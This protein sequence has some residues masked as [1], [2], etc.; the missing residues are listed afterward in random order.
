MVRSGVLWVIRK[1]LHALIKVVLWVAELALGLA[2]FAVIVNVFG[3]YVFK[4]PLNGSVEIV[5]LLLVV[6]VYFSLAYTEVRQGHVTMEEVVD[7]FPRRMK[8]VLMSIMY[9]AAAVFI[10]IL[11]WR[12]W[13]L[14]VQYTKPVFRVTDVLHLPIAPVVFVM[15]IG[16]VL[17]GLELLL[18]GFSPLPPEGGNKKEL[19]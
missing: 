6:I 17:F 8:R 15:A 12:S 9:F 2:A 3:R 10:L 1:V 7:R 19:E 16:M 14:A 5:Q 13:I 11:G 18:N 4:R